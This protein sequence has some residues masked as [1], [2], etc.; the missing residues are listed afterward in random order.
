[1]SLSYDYIMSSLGIFYTIHGVISLFVSIVAMKFLLH[2]FQTKYYQYLLFF[3][4]LNIS[5]P[6]VGYFMTLWIV[7]YLLHVEYEEQLTDINFINMIEFENEFHQV[8]R[9]FGES[10]M[11]RL[12]GGNDASISSLKMKALVSLADNASKHDV[13]LIKSSLSDRNDEVRL[14][15][16][17][18]IDKLERGINGQI[19]DIMELFD[20]TKEEEKRAKI[21]EDLAHLYWDLV[22]FELADSYLKTF[23][24]KEV[25]KYAT[26]ALEYNF[27]NIK[28]NVLLGKTYLAQEDINRAEEYFTR[29][30]NHGANMDFIIPYLAEIF[31]I[32]KDFSKVREL[33]SE[34][35]GL[36]IS[37]LLYPLTVQWE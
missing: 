7:Y 22:Y 9:V 27:Y 6:I 20:A 2:K 15:S 30:I 32:K 25:I 34:A 5:L 29:A 13:A 16:F 4:M 1:M 37:M 12:L 8:S 26:I 14:Y 24:L 18:V 23:V 3:W 19:H 31:F 11:K 35:N 21:A 28:V 17:A 36:H 10:S 33:L